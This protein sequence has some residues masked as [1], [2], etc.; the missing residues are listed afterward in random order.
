MHDHGLL[1]HLQL[2]YPTTGTQLH[3]CTTSGNLAASLTTKKPT[4]VAYQCA[5]ISLVNAVRPNRYTP[6]AAAPSTVPRAAARSDPALNGA[7][8]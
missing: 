2:A 5:N 7:K 8:P 4:V 1:Y 6:N 3:S